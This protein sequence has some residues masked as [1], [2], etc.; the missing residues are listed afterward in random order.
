MPSLN[1]FGFV[2]EPSAIE[3]GDRISSDETLLIRPT[4]AAGGNRTNESNVPKLDPI[5]EAQ[6]LKTILM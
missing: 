6:S 3:A 1:D 2:D 5:L 4:G